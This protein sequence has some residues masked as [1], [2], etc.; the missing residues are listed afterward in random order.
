MSQ[1]QQ[2]TMET[3][4]ERGYIVGSVERRKRF[5]A[6]GKQRCKA[7][8]AVQMVDIAHDLFNVFDLI[9]FK[10]P[11]EEKW[12]Q[13]VLVQSTSA[14]NHATRRTKILTSPE[15]KFWMQSGGMICLQSWSKVKNRWQP[16]DEWITLDMFPRSLP[17]TVEDFY[18][19]QRRSKLPDLPPGTTLLREGIKDAEIPF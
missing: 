15:A 4:R 6:R 12:D 13:I 16:R 14:A 7:C 5:P 18:E 11:T 1:L 9:A 3:F 10:P 2:R 19:D 8:G 17:A